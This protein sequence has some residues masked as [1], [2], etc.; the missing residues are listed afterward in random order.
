MIEDIVSSWRGSPPT[1]GWRD[2]G[3]KFLVFSII[4]GSYGIFRVIGRRNAYRVSQLCKM[5]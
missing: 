2:L 4:V 5:G 3:C 1:E